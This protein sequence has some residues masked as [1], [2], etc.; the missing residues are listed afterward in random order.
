[1]NNN[2]PMPLTSED[3]NRRSE[4]RIPFIKVEL[5]SLERVAGGDLVAWARLVLMAAAKV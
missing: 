2:K 3:D 4:V 1:M 5:A